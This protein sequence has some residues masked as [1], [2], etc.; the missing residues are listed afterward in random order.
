MNK[1]IEG[2]IE[3][4]AQASDFI[5]NLKEGEYSREHNAVFVSSIGQH[6]R[7]VLDLYFALIHPKQTWLVDYDHRRR[8]F[9]VETKRKQ[10]LK[11]LKI[12]RQWL[13]ELTEEQICQPC[14]I[15]TEVKLSCSKPV[16][17][18]TTIERELCF[19]A[20]HL[21]HHLALMA[22]MARSRGQDVEVGV[23]MAPATLTHLRSQ[24]K[25]GSSKKTRTEDV[26]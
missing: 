12:V 4:I 22:A 10:G 1:V 11:E 24:Q 2:N 15:Q 6:L 17:V 18:Q 21:T 26:T 9:L 3:A 19:V 7:H 20:S 16:L 25:A 5:E 23:G 13:K 8:G 14:T